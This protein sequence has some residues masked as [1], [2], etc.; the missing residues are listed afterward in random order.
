L[1]GSPAP[2]T[3][4]E[5][6]ID[7]PALFVPTRSILC[8]PLALLHSDTC[9]EMLV[10]VFTITCPALLTAIGELG[11]DPGTATTLNAT[12]ANANPENNRTDNATIKTLFTCF[13]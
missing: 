2:T 10:P 6:L 9:A 12:C 5:L 7:D 4:P 1:L 13:K 3:S 11:L 8:A